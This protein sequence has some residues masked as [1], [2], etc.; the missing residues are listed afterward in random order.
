MS[1]LV[2][3]P[4]T[5]SAGRRVR[6]DLNALRAFGSVAREKSAI[7]GELAVERVQ[8]GI[9]LGYQ[10]S[11]GI[12]ALNRLNQ[13]AGASNPELEAELSVIE[14]AVVLGIRAVIVDY[15]SRPA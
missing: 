8:T 3:L 13:Q 14:E 5:G 2:P 4:A 11:L 12:I 10:A 9:R 7:E 15:L 1:E 6:G